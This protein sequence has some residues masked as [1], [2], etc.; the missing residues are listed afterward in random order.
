MALRLIG[1]GAD[2]QRTLDNEIG[3]GQR[4]GSGATIGEEFESANFIDGGFF[5]R[6]AQQMADTVSDDES[7]ESWVQP[8]RTLK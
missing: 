5:G 2:Q 6:K 7:A 8:F 3:R 4:D 1:E